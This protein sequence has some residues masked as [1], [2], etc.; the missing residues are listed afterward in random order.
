MFS[1]IDDVNS[2]YAVCN[3]FLNDL[4]E[5][6]L[7]MNFS[8]SL[9]IEYTVNLFDLPKNILPRQKTNNNLINIFK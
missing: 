1:N 3:H 5:P 4:F 7:D 9:I 6:T 8:T 2:S